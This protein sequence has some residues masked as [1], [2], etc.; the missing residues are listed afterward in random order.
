MQPV[1]RMTRRFSCTNERFH[2]VTSLATSLFCIRSH[3]T[4]ALLHATWTQLLAGLMSF[5]R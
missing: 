1:L 3:Y 5:Y 4:L 2:L